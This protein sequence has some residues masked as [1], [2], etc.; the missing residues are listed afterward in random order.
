MALFICLII[1]STA[2]CIRIRW[3]V[4]RPMLLAGFDKEDEKTVGAEEEWMSNVQEMKLIR[5][6]N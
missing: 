4:E 2:D 3:E 6:K 1:S 5:Q